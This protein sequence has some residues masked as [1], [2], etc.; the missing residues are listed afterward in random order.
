MTLYTKEMRQIQG[1]SAE[2]ISNMT[3]CK[4]TCKF[5][6][7]YKVMR[8]N[9]KMKGDEKDKAS[10]HIKIENVINVKNETIIMTLGNL[11]AELGGALG[12]FLGFSFVMIVDWLEYLIRILINIF[13]RK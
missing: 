2:N 5:N 10:L 12:L 7:Y 8:L 9:H 13:T 11:I 4:R 6:R 3:G 1:L